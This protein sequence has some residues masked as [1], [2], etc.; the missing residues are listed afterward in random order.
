MGFIE[1]FFNRGNNN[2]EF[3]L[4]MFKSEYEFIYRCVMEFEEMETG[5]DLFGNWS[6]GA[7]PI[8]HYV[9]GPG[10]NVKR[11]S[12]AFYQDREFL[13]AAGN[14]LYKKYGLG[15][16]GEW[17][18]HHRLGLQEPSGGDINTIRNAFSNPKYALNRFILMICNIHGNQ[19][20]LNPYLFYRH[21]KDI[22]MSKCELVIIDED[23]P[24]RITF[25]R[26]YKDFVYLP[27]ND[28][29]SVNLGNYKTTE[30]NSKAEVAEFPKG[31]WL[32]DNKGKEYLKYIYKD[33]K[34]YFDDVKMF[35]NSNGSVF[36]ECSKESI[37]FV[38]DLPLNFPIGKPLIIRK[39]EKNTKL[40]NEVN[41][42]Y[43][44]KQNITTD[45]II[46]CVTAFMNPNSKIEIKI[47]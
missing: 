26:N 5:G 25:D 29:A 44:W 21:N 35:P 13:I 45:Y 47:N 14:T 18:S 31:S 7:N 6:N 39:N 36:L 27:K 43:Q 22:Q 9:L 33:L 24:T 11:T 1:K 12:T 23:S 15:H 46:A 40:I 4:T 8:V 28:T 38:V 2:N 19:V 30:E 34:N 16:I 32:D 17:H 41:N 10:Q 37:V 3:T 20:I 42:K